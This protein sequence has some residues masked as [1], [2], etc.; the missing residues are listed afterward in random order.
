MND[1]GERRIGRMNTI[2]NVEIFPSFCDEHV[3]FF[4]DLENNF[5]FRGKFVLRIKLELIAS[6]FGN[7]VCFD[8]VVVSVLDAAGRGHEGRLEKAGINCAKL[9]LQLPDVLNGF[10]DD[11][12]LVDVRLL[13]ER[14]DDGAERLELAVRLRRLG[15]LHLQRLLNGA[16]RLEG[17]HLRH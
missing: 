6:T 15:L 13:G 3:L 17:G 12:Q 8:V 2:T 10:K 4:V 9:F 16:D 14:R 1:E 5:F 11:L 7:K